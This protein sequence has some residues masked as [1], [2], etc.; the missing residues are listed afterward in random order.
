MAQPSCKRRL[1]LLALFLGAV[2]AA[3]AGRLVWLQVVRHEYYRDIAE[4]NTQRIFFLEPRRGDIVDI[5]NN[6]LA[7]S[8]PV[9][10]VCA[11][12]RYLGPHAAD[13]AR[14]LAP[15][16][17]WDESQLARR[18]QPVTYR[19]GR[20]ALVTNSYVNLKRKLNLERWQQVT[21]AMARLS[22]NLDEKKLTRERRAFYRNLR[23]YSIYA[24]DDQQRFCPSASLAAHVLGFVQEEEREFNDKAVIEIAGKDGIESWLNQP[25]S[26][27]RGWR[28]TQTDRRRQELVVF[29]EQ[30][31]DPRSGLNVVLSLDLVIQSFVESEL[32]EAVKKHTPASASALVVRPR[33]G[34]ILALATFPE[35]DPNRPGD[36]PVEARRNRVISDTFE[37]GSTFKIVVVS[38]ALSDQLVSLSDVFDCEQGYFRFMGRTLR[39]HERYGVLSVENI[40]TKSSN[41]GAAKIGIKMGEQRLYELIRAFGFGARTGITLPGEVQGIVHAVR[42]WDRLTISRLPMGQAISVTPLQMTMAMC[43]IANEGRLMQPKLVHRLQ[44]QNGRVFAEYPS[45]TVRQVISERAARQMVAALKTVVSKEGTGF[46]AALEH[47]TVAG[48]TGTAQKAGVGGYAP[49][50]YFASFLGFFPAD[51]PEVCIGVFLDEPQQGYYGGQTA[52]PVFRNIAEQVAKYLCIRPDRGER[53]SDA[54][55]LGGGPATAATNGAHR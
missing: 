55:G 44:E 41:I 4:R 34:E 26:G 50:K 23:L 40:I 51:D 29:R 35:Y 17:D 12:P 21:Q 9:K 47:Y 45:Q 19:N 3:L 30:N 38:G 36:S 14:V 5:H 27:V 28:V 32:A 8:V 7:T 33:T 39:D 31:V 43:A 25:L 20:G 42:N 6:P 24:A 22:F 1:L 52:A 13:V 48:K 53:L 54:V 46:K 11:N 15:L 16:L 49:G 37:P 2:F 10:R 18:L